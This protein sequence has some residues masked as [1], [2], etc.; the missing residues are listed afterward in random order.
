MHSSMWE[1]QGVVRKALKYGE[2]SIENYRKALEEIREI[3]AEYE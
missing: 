1:I 2:P 3:A